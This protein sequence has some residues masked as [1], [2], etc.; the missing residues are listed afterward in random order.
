M[1]WTPETGQVRT[2]S[3]SQRRAMIDGDLPD[4]SVVRQRE[5]LS[6]S[7]S[8]V[9]YRPVEA[10]ERELELMSLIDKQC[11]RTPF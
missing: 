6:N 2:M 9:H 11:L 3:R 8:S 10:S 5:L 1:R 7:R 4:V